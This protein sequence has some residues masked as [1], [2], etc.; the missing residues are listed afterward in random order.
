MALAMIL[1]SVVFPHPFGPDSIIDWFPSDPFLLRAK[2]SRTTPEFPMT[3][4]KLLG[5]YFRSSARAR[6][7]SSY[8]G[9]DDITYW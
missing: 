7:S 5:R 2:R 6:I 1:A 8:T 3:C 9:T 4:E